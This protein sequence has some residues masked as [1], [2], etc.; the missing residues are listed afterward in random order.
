MKQ[1]QKKKNRFR[2]RLAAVILVIIALLL[3]LNL[4][5][6]HWIGRSNYVSDE[7]VEVMTELLETEAVIHASDVYHPEDV[8]AASP[9]QVKDTWSLL[10]I[11][12]TA[13]EEPSSEASD[14]SPSEDGTGTPTGY[15]T[16]AGIVLMTISHPLREVFFH[17]FHT[18]LYTDIEGYG[19]HS[20]AD[21]YAAGGGPLLVDTI[22]RNY[23]VSIDQYASIRLDMVAQVLG[24]DDFTDLDINTK[25]VDVIEDLVYGMQDV[26]PPM[27]LGYLSKLLPYVTHNMT[28]GQIMS[29]ALQVP[30]V[31]QY[32]S[33]KDILPY[34][35]LYQELDGYLVPDIGLTSR[36]LQETIYAK[37]ETE[38][39]LT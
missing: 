4:V 22:M 12:E 5:L 10:V 13:P 23:G 1:E 30:K 18:G 19:G 26:A 32:Y 21:A 27:M 38:T 36:R 35:G 37:P 39:P 25:G 2:T 14:A 24:M 28:D 9:A 20:L 29:L 8:K 17:S 16:P 6:R 33:E 11:A 15:G 3:I 31:V 7:D 34:E